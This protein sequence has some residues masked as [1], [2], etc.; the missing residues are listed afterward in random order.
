MHC[1]KL[2]T[3]LIGFY[4]IRIRTLNSQISKIP[5]RKDLP[6]TL[7]YKK[8]FPWQFDKIK[9]KFIFAHQLLL[10]K[11]II[12][13]HRALNFFICNAKQEI[14]LTLPN[15]FFWWALALLL[16]NSIGWFLFEFWFLASLPQRNIHK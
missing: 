14:N 3:S 6:L 2:S 16:L 12:L 11:K 5:N 13:G 10:R 9:R 4:S 1:E 15:I 8:S 7:L